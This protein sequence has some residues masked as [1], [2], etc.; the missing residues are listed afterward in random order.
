MGW[1]VLTTYN[2]WARLPPSNRRYISDNKNIPYQNRIPLQLGITE[3]GIVNYRLYGMACI[4]HIIQ[5]LKKPT[6]ISHI[7]D[8]NN[9]LYQY[10]IPI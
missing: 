2:N 5:N 6:L 9:M 4:D 10:R 8:H 3:W 1:P 7:S